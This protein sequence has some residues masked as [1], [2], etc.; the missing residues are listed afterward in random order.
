[1]ERERWNAECCIL[2][3]LGM[4][5]VEPGWLW[6]SFSWGTEK[7]RGSEQSRVMDD[8][9]KRCCWGLGTQG[10]YRSY[11]VPWRLVYNDIQWYA[12]SCN[13]GE[14]VNTVHYDVLPIVKSAILLLHLPLS[15]LLCHRVSG[16]HYYNLDEEPSL[17]AAIMLLCSQMPSHWEIWSTTYP[18]QP[19]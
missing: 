19:K 15:Q 4:L 9:V 14:D 16:T 12:I 10:H 11:P 2:A 3:F 17:C 13:V 5:V 7:K 8:L 18:R 6:E 1:M